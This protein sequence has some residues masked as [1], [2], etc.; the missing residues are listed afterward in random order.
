[1]DL[2]NFAFG[3]RGKEWGVDDDTIKGRVCALEFCRQREEIRGDEILPVDGEAIQWIG[4][5]GNVKESTV[6]VMLHDVFRAARKGRN[7]KA[8]RVCKCIENGFISHVFDEPFSQIA[9]VEIK[10]CVAV[11]RQVNR[12]PDA[13]FFDFCIWLFAKD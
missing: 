13:V 7:P 5:F 10:A 12:I 11:Y 6:E 4:G 2:I 9:R 8:A 3:C 1:M